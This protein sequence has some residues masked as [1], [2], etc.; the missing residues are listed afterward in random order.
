MSSKISGIIFM[1][2][3]MLV[4][5]LLLNM[6]GH[7]IDK[8]AYIGFSYIHAKKIIMKSGTYIGHGNV[9]T[10]LDRLVMN[11]GSRIN[12][13][14]RITSGVNYDGELQ[15]GARSSISLRHYLDVCDVFT[16]GHDTIIAGHRSTFFTHSKGIDCVDYVKPIVIGD[17]CYV[18]SNVCFVPGAGIGS[19]CFVGMGAV[20]TKDFT[21]TKYALIAG[22]PAAS[23]KTID[24]DS[25][26]FRQEKLVHQHH[27]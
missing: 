22:N 8:T 21:E 4:K 13:W 20:V 1:F 3:P 19:N 23:R 14:N 15:I 9:I 17:W 6:I 2:L 18:G 16:I 27:T 7:D 24:K 25:A 10:N 12:R 5:R 26:Y 11:D